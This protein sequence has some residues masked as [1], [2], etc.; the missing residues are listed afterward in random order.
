M[1]GAAVLAA[2][3]ALAAFGFVYVYRLVHAWIWH[4]QRCY[5][6]TEMRWIDR[7]CWWACRTVRGRIS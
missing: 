6:F 4:C 5:A 2:L 1:L 7:A 3:G